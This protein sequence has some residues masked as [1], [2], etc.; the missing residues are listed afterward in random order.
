MK[1][2]N[3]INKLEAIEAHVNQKVSS[4]IQGMF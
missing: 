3:L 4:S 2:H 1:K